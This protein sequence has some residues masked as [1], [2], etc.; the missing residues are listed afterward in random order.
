MDARKLASILAAVLLAITGLSRAADAGRIEPLDGEPSV[1]RLSD[2]RAG[3]S[4]LGTPLAIPQ[5]DPPPHGTGP[6]GAPL[7]P[8]Q[9]TPAP[10]L[11]FN[12]NGHLMPA[13]SA[14]FHPPNPA[15]AETRAYPGH[16]PNPAY[17]GGGRTGR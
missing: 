2:T 17:S 5:G 4:P 9:L 12:P 3:H 8:Q 10:V 11:P 13:P 14:P 7:P 16:P 6:F 15:P 1:N